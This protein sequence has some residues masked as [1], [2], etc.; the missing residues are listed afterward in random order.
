[1]IEN[2]YIDTRG[3]HTKPISFTEAVIHGQAQGGGLFVPQSVPH[4]TLDEIISLS[5]MSYSQRAA[6]IYKRFGIDLDTE[7]ID[8]LA[9][10]A[11][12]TKL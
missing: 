2:N 8:S 7:T 3:L 4:L 11:Y 6:L 9:D 5:D 12:G 10:K 1:M